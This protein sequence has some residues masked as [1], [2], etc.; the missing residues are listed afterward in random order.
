MFSGLFELFFGCLEL[1]FFEADLKLLRLFNV[2]ADCLRLFS[3]FLSFYS[4]FRLFKKVEFVVDCFRF[5][6]FVSICSEMYQF[7]S[8]RLHF[9]TFCELFQLFLIPSSCQICFYVVRCSSGRSDRF[10]SQLVCSSVVCSISLGWLDCTGCQ[11]S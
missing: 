2:V 3:I 4:L 1:S 9:F 10:R 5:F 11:K 7:G 8:I 6:T